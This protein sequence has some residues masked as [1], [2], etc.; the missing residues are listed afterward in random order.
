LA[1]ASTTR[2]DAAERFRHGN[3]QA[4]ELILRDVQRYGSDSLMVMWARK[5]LDTANSE[6]RRI[7]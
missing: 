5:T 7:A 4:A 1:A 2:P 3:I 6:S